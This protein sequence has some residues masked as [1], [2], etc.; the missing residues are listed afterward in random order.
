QLEG[1]TLLASKH[2]FRLYLHKVWWPIVSYQIGD[3]S[4]TAI[5]DTGTSTSV[6]QDDDDFPEDQFEH[7]GEDVLAV[8]IGNDLFSVSYGLLHEIHIGGDVFQDI[9]VNILHPEVFVDA[10]D[11]ENLDVLG[12]SLLLLY[13][14]VCFAWKER[15]LYLGELGPCAD[16]LAVSAA[17]SGRS[18]LYIEI[19]TEYESRQWNAFFDTGAKLTYCSPEMYRDNDKRVFFANLNKKLVGTCELADDLLAGD[20]DFM[21]PSLQS[22]IIGLDTLQQFEAWGWKRDPLTSYFV[23]N[24]TQR[25]TD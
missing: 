20:D 6:L 19:G 5:V 2:H 7:S 11:I 13:D 21:N 25:E 1:N 12:M 24:K 22:G 15:R 17:L 18:E 16:G 9:L 4:R 8:G 3:I 10:Q 23:R 14:S